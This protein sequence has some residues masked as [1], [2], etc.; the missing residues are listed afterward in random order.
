MQ[1]P[2]SIELRRSFFLFSSLG[3]MHCVA[4][5]AV[6]FVPLHWLLRLTW[7]ATILVSAVLALR[8]TCIASLHLKRDGSLY[9][10]LQDGRRVAATPLD[11]S[12]VLP[13]LV[14]L[15]LRLEDKLATISLPLF[16]DHMSGEEFRALKVWLRWGATSKDDPG[17]S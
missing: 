4:A 3:I 15:R 2:V 17:V 11:G 8:P 10:A 12:A 16:P 5:A 7:V 6:F 9:C 14:V 1:F 13:G